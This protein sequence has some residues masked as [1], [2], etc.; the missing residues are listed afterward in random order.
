MLAK[1]AVENFLNRELDSYDWLK[2]VSDKQLDYALKQLDPPFAF[3]TKPF[4]NQKVG[5]L[6]GQQC[7]EFLFFYDLGLGKT[8][9]ILDLFSYAR[10]CGEAK[11]ALVLVPNILNIEGWEEQ[12]EEHAPALKIVSLEGTKKQREDLLDSDAH[13]YIINYDGLLALCTSLLPANKASHKKYLQVLRIEDQIEKI[14]KR[15]PKVRNKTRLR[16]KRDALQAR[17]KR[18]NRTIKRKRQID[19]RL[20]R[21]LARRFDTIIFDESTRLMHTTSLTFRVCRYFSKR[22][23]TRYSLTGTPMGRDPLAFWGQFYVTDHGKTLGKTLGI[24]RTAFFDMEQNYWGTR[25]YTFKKEM[26][27]Q[28]GELLKNRSIA[29]EEKECVDLPKKV[30]TKVYVQFTRD[31]EKFYEDAV[32]DAID[33][34]GNV[35]LMKNSFMRMRQITSGYMRYRDSEN[36]ISEI[37]FKENPKIDAL[38]DIIQ[39]IPPKRKFVIFY[40]FNY[41]GKKITEALD[42]LQVN[43]VRIWARDKAV[44]KKADMRKFKKDKR[45]R[46]LVINNKSGAF[47]HNLQMANYVILYEGAVSP[48]VDRQ[49]KKRCHRRGQK[50][51]VFYFILLMKKSID[52]KIYMFVKEGRRLLKALIRGKESWR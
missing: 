10:Q 34:S 24:F 32:Q 26:E 1:S 13:L 16:E 7:P 37:H 30:F 36:V 17:I 50:R 27:E 52:I 21:E 25:E 38:I 22:C 11:R 2:K 47:G 31:A 3:H 23:K 4:T 49:V 8:K 41:S 33:A 28:F 9:L 14:K 18:I 15:I 43:H 5:F 6:I 29:Y 51:K 45:C 19:K 20:M 39:K 46:G 44:I 48:I 42:E 40:E 12:C 35:T